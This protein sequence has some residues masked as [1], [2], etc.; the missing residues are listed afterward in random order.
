MGLVVQ[1]ERWP[2]ATAIVLATEDVVAHKLIGH[3]EGNMGGK[4]HDL[5]TIPLAADEHHRFHHDPREWEARHGSQ[6]FYVKQTIKR[7]L[8]FGALV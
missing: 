3:G 1:I 2:M 5:F 8:E 4:T 7:A 6:L